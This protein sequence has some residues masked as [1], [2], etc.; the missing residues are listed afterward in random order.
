MVESSVSAS[1][2]PSVAVLF[3]PGTVPIIDI[4]RA[5]GDFEDHYDVAALDTLEDDLAEAMGR[6]AA[7]GIVS[8]ALLLA[9][10]LRR[11][12][13]E[14]MQYGPRQSRRGTL[15][16][17]RLMSLLSATYWHDFIL[18]AEAAAALEIIHPQPLISLAFD[19][20][21]RLEG[22]GLKLDAPDARVFRPVPQPA[23]QVVVE[24]ARPALAP[25]RHIDV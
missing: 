17:Y 4:F 16:E 12:R 9:F 7:K 5:L 19:I 11:E 6:D 15:D 20:S 14:P 24:R 1:V 22:A 23:A 25:L 8:D 13:P 10:G 18:A 3:S 2:G 21:R